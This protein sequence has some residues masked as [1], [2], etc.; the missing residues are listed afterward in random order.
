MNSKIFLGNL[1]HKYILSN[2][3]CYSKC[4]L[5]VIVKIIIF[6][7]LIWLNSPIY[8]ATNL[9][10]ETG[11]MKVARCEFTATL[12]KD[13][14]VLAVGGGTLDCNTQTATAEIYDYNSGQWTETA[15]M[16]TPREVHQ[17]VMLAN[18]NILVSGGYRYINNIFTI[19]NSAEIYDTV[20]TKWTKTGNM[21][22]SRH[23]AFIAL[24]P[25]GKVLVAGGSTPTE[26]GTA[27]AELYDPNAGTWSY[28]GNMR[29]RRMRNS[30][31]P[32]NIQVLPNGKVL[33]VGGH[34]GYPYEWID[35]AEL[36]DPSTGTWTSTNSKA[37]HALGAL[38]PLS[39]GRI[40]VAGGHYGLQGGDA[41]IAD[42][43]IFDPSNG[44][45][46]ATGS[47][48][49]DMIGPMVSLMD[50]K[51]LMA[52][53][54]HQEWGGGK[55]GPLRSGVLYDPKTQAWVE[56]PSLV[57]PR[58]GHIA[59]KLMNG[60]VLIA[61]GRSD[62][63]N[64]LSSAELYIPEFSNLSPAISSFTATRKS[65][66]PPLSVTFVATAKDPDGT[67]ASYNWDFDGDGK[68]DQTTLK[69]KVTHIYNELGIFNSSVTVVDNQGTETKSSAIP[70]SI[71]YGPDL[72]GTVETYTFN[73]STNTIHIDF[74]VTNQGDIPV[75]GFS[76]TFNAS[77]DGTTSAFKFN[78]AQVEKLA[79]GESKSF[80]V[81]QTFRNPIYGRWVLIL[82]DP[83]KEVAE[84]NEKN[85][86]SRVIVQSAPTN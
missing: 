51:V 16:S 35:D 77:N 60:K 42:A 85:N 40:L 64:T 43:E 12:L 37:T 38:T 72:V 18:G 76:I 7:N 20:S 1:K 81:D 28:T 29:H 3:F 63:K 61:G 25:N 44:S 62:C 14:K 54:A 83:N 39:D 71:A 23:S 53:G 84:I 36:Y 68:M 80:S 74:K 86:G 31:A 50:G 67:I 6:L 75:N 30:V 66:N 55:C 8:A 11:S 17:T 32:G 56:T 41:T 4:L 9:W 49:H 22:V 2:I 46:S 70:I 21:N 59:I 78:E 15:S 24:L 33:I 57:H 26:Y 48:P 65:G 27:S 52:G 13:G 45:W 34:L 73:K 79:V 82:I 19:L 47:L 5:P 10:E 58:D 69:G